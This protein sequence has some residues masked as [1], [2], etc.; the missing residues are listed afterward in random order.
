MMSWLYGL[1]MIPGNYTVQTVEFGAW[2]NSRITRSSVTQEAYPSCASAVVQLGL[3]AA[4]PGE[5]STLSQEDL[6]YPAA[7]L[8]EH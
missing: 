8:V 7:M 5:E 4:H 1:N 3:G 2:P 6:L